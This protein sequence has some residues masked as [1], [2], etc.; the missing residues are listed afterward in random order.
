MLSRPKSLRSG[1]PGH[2]A[3]RD[4]CS[5][6]SSRQSGPTAHITPKASIHGPSFA[7]KIREMAIDERQLVRRCLCKLS[8]NS[9]KID[10]GNEA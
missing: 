8:F 4:A 5:P 10:G 9:E 6:L 3:A 7:A 1:Q 2:G